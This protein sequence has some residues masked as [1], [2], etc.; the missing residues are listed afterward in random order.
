M[1]PTP[2]EERLCAKLAQ[3]VSAAVQY[4]YSYDFV[5]KEDIRHWVENTLADWEYDE[6]R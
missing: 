3:H 1:S 5:T 2:D 6:V 4:A